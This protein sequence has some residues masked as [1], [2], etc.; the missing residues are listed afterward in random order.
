MMYL[1]NVAL[2]IT[3]PIEKIFFD[4]INAINGLNLKHTDFVL[5]PPEAVTTAGALYNTKVVISP[6]TTSQFYNNFTVYYNRMNITEILNNPE[7]SI[8]RVNETH[9][10]DLIE[11]INL[12]YNINATALDYYDSVISAPDPADP[13]AEVDVMF[14]AKPESY[15]F[16]GAYQLTLNRIALTPSI[17]AVASAV[18]MIVLDQPY[19]PVFKSNIVCRSTLGDT[20][21]NF[22]FM[23]NAQTINKVKINKA[24]DIPLRGTM[25]F[26]EFEF[27][28]DLG[29]GMETHTGSA[30]LISTM[31]KILSINSDDFSANNHQALKYHVSKDGA[32]VYALDPTDTL[33]TE[34]SKL[35][36][37]KTD[38]ALDTDFQTA[39]ITYAIEYIKTDAQGRIYTVSELLNVPSDHDNDPGTPAIINKEYWI[40]RLNSNGSKDISFVKAALSITGA[41]DPWP[42]ACI[43]PIEGD[44]TTTTSGFYVGLAMTEQPR[45]QGNSPVVNYTPIIPG[46]EPEYGFLPVLKFY[47]NG[48]P[49]FTFQAAQKLCK[50]EAVYAYEVGKQPFAGDEFVS[51]VGNSVVILA[52]RANPLSGNMQKLPML[53]SQT[54]ES[55]K[56]TGTDYLNSYYLT[57]ARSIQTVKINQMVVFGEYTPISV[58][59]G[60]GMSTQAVLTYNDKAAPLA[61]AYTV[62]SSASGTP[63]IQQVILKE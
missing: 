25:L 37:F 41:A 11:Q 21:D 39:S 59:G 60:Y 30:M 13:E 34:A 35:Y 36:R 45:S 32:F 1:D 46:N 12:K 15:L 19:E 49:D 50:P 24:F 61:I 5:Q 4:K 28:A 42:V 56:L 51:A 20:I 10:S 53:Y 47:E 23:R 31:G 57:N 44:R 9:L 18:A 48:V 17:S 54:G 38:G 55:L 43:D 27:L 14:S 40:D 22:V 3:D 7:V 58:M 63:S 2:N 16:T 6:K 29:T 8:K 26:G 52:Y 62:E 33:G